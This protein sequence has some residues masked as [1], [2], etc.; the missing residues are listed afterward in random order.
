[1]EGGEPGGVNPRAAARERGSIIVAMATASRAPLRAALALLAFTGSPAAA[2]WNSSPGVPVTPAAA[3]CVPQLAV[4]DGLGGA[5]L[6]LD[7]PSG[8]SDIGVFVQH[9]TASGEVA[10]GW[11]AGGAPVGVASTD[12]PGCL[13][14]HVLQPAAASDGAGGV[15]VSWAGPP[16]DSNSSVPTLH[17]QHVDASGQRAAGWPAA[18]LPATTGPGEVASTLYRDGSG[19]V[20]VVWFDVRE[21]FP[22]TSTADDP[23]IMVQHMLASGALAPGFTALG[24]FLGSGVPPVHER[25]LEASF[26]QDPT[27]GAWAIVARASADTT[28]E[29]AAFIVM[30]FDA[31]GLV[32]DGFG[33]DGIILPGPSADMGG[34]DLKPSHIVPDGGGGAWALVASSARGATIAFHV[35]ADGSFDP[36]LPAAGLTL[37]ALPGEIV[38]PDGNAGFFV[39]VVTG[40][41]ALMLRRIEPDGS[42]DPAW[43][44]PIAICGELDATL[45]P[46]A[47]GVLAAGW[48][49]LASRF[50]RTLTGEALVGRLARD[51]SIPPDWPRDGVLTHGVAAAVNVSAAT[52]EMATVACAVGDAGFIVAWR[53]GLASDP[54]AS[55]GEVRAMRY[56]LQG[57]LAGVEAPGGGRATGLRARWIAGAGIRA[58]VAAA[59]ETR[60]LDVSDLLGRRVAAAEVAPGAREVT[61]AGTGG[62][63]PGLYF[64]RLRAPGGAERAKVL[65]RR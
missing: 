43:A 23:H 8:T 17:V 20:F 10:V 37:A 12:A 21:L 3:A 24:R 32:A 26:A 30:R 27:G 51:G 49:G 36:A 6:V 9:L 63:R 54:P 19:G 38:E 1:V 5:F 28:V 15:Y 39:R 57:A 44:P 14:D 29:R 55:P 2:A 48:L 65:V 34:P 33:E 62:L 61:V 46:T 40:S 52:S 60:R 47:D 11:P 41:G 18:G 50:C 4:P 13:P 25:R 58:E 7:G 64:L 35:L 56:T 45:F 42:A 31:S 22:P 16:I 53:V 59:T